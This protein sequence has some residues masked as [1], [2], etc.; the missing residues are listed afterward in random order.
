MDTIFLLDQHERTIGHFSNEA[1]QA[2]PYYADKWSEDL[3]TGAST[4][5]FM[6]PANHE[7]AGRISKQGYII[8]QDFAGD[9]MQF[10]ITRIEEVH[11]DEVIYKYVFCEFAWAELNG[12]IVRPYDLPGTDPATALRYALGG[13]RW[14]PGKVEF[15]GT[16]DLSSSTYDTSLKMAHDI[17]DAFG[18]E[19]KFRVT[20]ENNEI[21]GRFVDLLEQVGENQGQII[22]FERNLTSAKR[23]HD[24]TTVA[25]ALIG[26]GKGDASG[27]QVTFTQEVWSKAAGNHQDKPAGQD[28]IGDDNALKMWGVE[29]RHIMQVYEYDTTSPAVLL[30][31]TWEELQRRKNGLLQYE[32]GAAFLA[33]FDYDWARNN[34]GNTVLIQDY[35]FEPPLMVNAR[36]IKLERSFTNPLEQ[37]ATFGDYEEAIS[38]ASALADIQSTLLKRETQWSEAAAGGA[39]IVRSETAPEQTDNVIWVQPAAGERPYDLIRTYN[40]TSGLWE[41][42]APLDPADIGAQGE[43]RSGTTA[44][45][46]PYVGMVWADTSSVPN[47]LRMWD[48]STWIGFSPTDPTQI[49]AEAAIFKQATAP[50]HLEGRLWVDTSQTPNIIYRSS[51]GVWIKTA[52]TIPGEI[53]AEQAIYKQA[54]A[55]AHAEGRIWIDTSATPNKQYRSSG[56]V[57]VNITPTAPGD[58][59]AETPAGAQNKAKIA[60]YQAYLKSADT[61]VADLDRRAEPIVAN[62]AYYTATIWNDVYNHRL[63]VQGTL[64]DV[65]LSITNNTADGVVSSGD[66]GDISYFKTEFEKAIKLLSEAI[67]RAAQDAGGILVGTI[68]GITLQVANAGITNAGT[69]STDIRIWAGQS[70]ANRATAPFRVTQA[71]A[72]YASNIT[73]T[74]GSINIAQ[75]ATVGNAL[76]LGSTGDYTSKFIYFNGYSRIEATD[77]AFD[78]YTGRFSVSDS[79]GQIL[80][81]D[82]GTVYVFGNMWDF[83]PA[84]VRFE[85]AAEVYGALRVYNTGISLNGLKGAGSSMYNNQ[86]T[87]GQWFSN[88]AESGY[89]GIQ[90]ETNGTTYT[91]GIGHGVNFKVSKDYTPSSITMTRTSGNL[92]NA[93]LY[94]GYISQH[95]FWLQVTRANVTAN[96]AWRGHYTA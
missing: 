30:L 70:Y 62:Q 56:G 3:E 77:N 15:F 36:I 73:I 63:Y 24:R 60:E 6:V 13:T 66:E 32:A 89:C 71:G 42:T 1:P 38:N 58:I 82:N 87:G 85:N 94:V 27:E 39:T 84:T 46:A 25:T 45:S 11:E 54:T 79:Q 4:Y 8:R 9:L 96:S 55:P 50:P 95:G 22:S 64:S 57:W 67:T 44:P 20:M 52:P 33:R 21:S 88:Y 17:K 49:G 93:Q 19:I 76:Y 69:L 34:I 47:V 61:I 80:E 28:W 83:Y 40:P 2:C 26:V 29:G 65:R 12:E 23:I 37:S 41:V 16:A 78:I 81:T 68:T 86:T 14:Q 75:N 10:Q 48:G 43:I 92:T 18:A 51:G 59:G 7:M 53:G 72:V 74:G 5:E 90:V 91:I 35:F 31:K